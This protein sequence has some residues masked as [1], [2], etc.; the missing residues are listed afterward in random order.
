MEFALCYYLNLLF[1]IID[2][3]DFI[4]FI[5]VITIA[6]IQYFVI[7]FNE[8]FKMK[9]NFLINVIFIVDVFQ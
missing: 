3:I 2:S 6:V 9:W 7:K 5:A 8:K 1:I 4:I